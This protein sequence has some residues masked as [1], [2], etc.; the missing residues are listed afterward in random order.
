MLLGNFEQHKNCILDAKNAKK[1]LQNQIISLN[2][3]KNEFMQIFCG[4]R[5]LECALWQKMKTWKCWKTT[6]SFLNQ[7]APTI[8]A[9]PLLKNY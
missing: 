8:I 2:T 6:E 5:V 4:F 3:L 7:K 9:L 1:I